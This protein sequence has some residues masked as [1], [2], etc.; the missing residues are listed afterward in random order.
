MDDGAVAPGGADRGLSDPLGDTATPAPAQ[1]LGP[2]ILRRLV[3]W[4][5][6]GNPVVKIVPTMPPKKM[7]GLAATALSMIYDG[8]EPQYRGMTMIEVNLAKRARI[9]ALSGSTEEGEALLDRAIGKP[10]S[11]SENVNVNLSGSYEDFLRGLAGAGGPPPSAPAAN[12]VDAEVIRP[13]PED[14]LA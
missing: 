3:D 7:Q 9:A 1:P 12:V 14:P 11:S 6:D 4:D 8:P 10:K 13:A 5:P 2:V